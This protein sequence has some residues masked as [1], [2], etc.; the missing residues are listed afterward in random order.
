MMFLAKV[1]FVQKVLLLD[2]SKMILIACALRKFV[3]GP[4][5]SGGQLIGLKLL[6]P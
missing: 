3:I 2:I 5:A 1:F 4:P 6:R